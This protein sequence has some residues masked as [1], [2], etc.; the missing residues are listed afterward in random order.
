MTIDR[1][2]FLELSLSGAAAAGAMAAVGAKAQTEPK[3][4][5]ALAARSPRTLDPLKSVLGADNW[6]L[7]S[8]FD[9]LVRPD[10]GTFAMNPSEYR[11]A[12]AEQ[13]ASSQ[14]AKTW[15]FRLRQGVNFHKGYGEMTSEDVKFTFDR[16]RDPT[17]QNPNRVLYDNIQ[18]VRTD[19]K[20]GIVFTLKRPDPIFCGTAIHTEGS[21]IVCKKAVL[22]KGA[23]FESDP[24]GTGAYQHSRTDPAKGV[25]LTGNPDY[26]D[27]PP[28]VNNLEVLYILDTTAR[29]L[30]LL[31]GQV[32]MIE[33]ARSPGWIQSMQLRQPNLKFDSTR[34]GSTNTLHFNM[35]QKPLDDLRVRQAIMYAL[36]RELIAKSMAPMGGVMYGLNPPQYEGTLNAKN[37]PPELQYKYD[38][39]KS[40][41]LLAE[42]GLANGVTIQAFTSQREDY[43]SHML[44][45]QELLRKVGINLDLKIID[46]TTFHA[47]CSKDLNAVP[48]HS[49]SY[50]P[51][52]TQI[53]LE[54]VSAAAC[55]KADG[56]GGNNFS[57]YGVVTP[58]IDKL[59]DQT[60]NEPDFAK[61]VALCT[62]ME[63]QILRD[64][65]VIGLSSLS[66]VIARNPRVDLGYVVKSGYARWTL[67]KA[68][69]AA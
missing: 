8:L 54:Q 41:K 13:F 61:R 36:D 60:L 1:R 68:T 28:K 11:P 4:S 32:D 27:G 16:A 25:Y 69:I 56:T 65:P 45:V 51:I 42:A 44:I 34:P 37:T 39:E 64:L 3:I 12:L 53:I 9:T 15:S 58:G 43:S 31:S 52:F 6:A 5:I 20:Y 2:R 63:K 38:P 24:I 26:F 47:N 67:R 55:V 21:N 17:E 57:H 35:T 59:L 30:A 7:D 23:K 40:K 19:G 18:D 46:H 10:D 29:T 14:D 62:E 33:A 48:M 66:Y 50:P 49:S 22:E